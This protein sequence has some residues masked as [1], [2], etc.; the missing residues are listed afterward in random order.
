[1]QYNKEIIEK[2]KLHDNDSGSVDIQIATLS[3]HIKILTD[4]LNIHQKD[5]HAKRGLMNKVN[6]RKR[7]LKYLKQKKNEKYISIIKYLNIRK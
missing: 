1:M 3:N 4:H 6:R 7:L 5:V 2:I